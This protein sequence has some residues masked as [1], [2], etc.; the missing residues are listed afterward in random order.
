MWDRIENQPK[1]VVFRTK[2]GKKKVVVRKAKSRKDL[3]FNTLLL[4]KEYNESHSQKTLA[5]ESSTT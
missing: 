1:V 3:A 4:F 2:D 5:R